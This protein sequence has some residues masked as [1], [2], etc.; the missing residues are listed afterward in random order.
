MLMRSQMEINAEQN[1]AKVGSIIKVLCEDYDPI[2][3]TMYGR[4]AADAPEIDGKVFFTF[5]G[6]RPSPGD[7][8]DVKIDEVMMYDLVGHVV[9]K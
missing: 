5:E 3:E 4:S 7:F 2:N 6:V 1:E 8:V 9:N